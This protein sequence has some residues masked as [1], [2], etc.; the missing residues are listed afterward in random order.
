M[1]EPTSSTRRTLITAAAVSL[2]T[3]VI[4]AAAQPVASRQDGGKFN[5]AQ[6]HERLKVVPNV[7][8][9]RIEEAGHMMHHDQPEV[10]ASL[11]ERFIA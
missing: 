5:L 6:Y 11:I 7:E 2:A 1:E 4:G 8:I 3:P 10:L 9:A